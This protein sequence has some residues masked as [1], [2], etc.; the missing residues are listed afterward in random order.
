MASAVRSCRRRCQKRVALDPGQQH[1]D[2]GLA[3]GQRVGHQLHGGPAEPPVGALDD[4]EGDLRETDVDPLAPECVGVLQVDGKVHGPQLVGHQ[5]AGVLDG[6]GCGQVEVANE[7]EDNMAAEDAGGRGPMGVLLQLGRF[8]DVL[9]FSR[10]SSSTRIGTM[11]MI[12]H[13]ALGELGDGDDHVDHEREHRADAVHEQAEAPT[14]F[15]EGGGGAWPCR[16][17]RG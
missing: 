11:T 4:V 1:G 14:R 3:L 15:L 5:G 17:A 8:G 10:S 12:T 7:D 2:L 16:P 6:A 13:P 9:V